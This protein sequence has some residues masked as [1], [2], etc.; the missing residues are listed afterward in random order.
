[1]SDY[2]KAAWETDRNKDGPDALMIP[3]LGL[4]GEVGSLL[5]EQKKKLRDKDKHRLFKERIEEDLGDILW[6]V[7]N[8]A[9]KSNIDL[10]H[11][12][13]KNLRKVRARWLK[14]PSDVYEL[15]DTDRPTHE[16][17]PRHFAI[18]FRMK[19]DHLHIFRDGKPIGDPLTDNAYVDDGYRYH[20]A[21]HLA[22]VAVLGWSPVA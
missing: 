9:S 1:F 2:Q 20:D 6:Y 12:A 10:D 8:F 21:F 15:F 14:P 17:F 22:Y 5:V 19:N 7:A 18:D 4:A 16:R 3:L 11:V 13:R